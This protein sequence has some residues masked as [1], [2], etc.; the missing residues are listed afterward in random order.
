MFKSAKV[1]GTL[2]QLDEVHFLADSFFISLVLTQLGTDAILA[3]RQHCWPGDS[4]NC[5]AAAQAQSCGLSHRQSRSQRL[6]YHTRRPQA[7]RIAL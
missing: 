5:D 3:S 7:G 2:P 4:R 6:A 1:T